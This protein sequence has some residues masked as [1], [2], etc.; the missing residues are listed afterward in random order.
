MIIEQIRTI[1]LS[2]LPWLL[3]IERPGSVRPPSKRSNKS[4]SPMEKQE[5]AN[6]SNKIKELEQLHASRHLMGQVMDQDDEFIQLN[7]TNR[8]SAGCH[9]YPNIDSFHSNVYNMQNRCEEQDISVYNTQLSDSPTEQICPQLSSCVRDLN[10]IIR[11]LRFITNRMRREDELQE[12]INEWKYAAIVIDRLCLILFST[13][14][15]IST[16]VCLLSAPHLI[17]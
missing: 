9:C 1:I 7:A 15:V 8:C 14:A 10:P 16:A 6:I 13:F 2:W 11:E 5:I 17:A 12:I 3:R 4:N